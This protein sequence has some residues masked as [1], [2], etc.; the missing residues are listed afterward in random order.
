[1]EVYVLVVL[2]MALLVARSDE[3]VTAFDWADTRGFRLRRRDG[4]GG[5]RRRYRGGVVRRPVAHLVVSTM[6]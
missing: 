5:H 4:G 2:L 6:S 1:V 3:V